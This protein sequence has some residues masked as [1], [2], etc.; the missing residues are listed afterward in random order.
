MS[1]LANKNGNTELR[2]HLFANVSTLALLGYIC[3]T[4]QTALASENGRPTVWIELG[5]QLERV[6]TE[7]TIF[8]PA[9]FDLASQADRDVMIGSQR[10]SRYSIGGAGKIS[11]EPEG[12]DWVFSA[13]VRYG[14]SNSA[15]HRHHEGPQLPVQYNTYLGN[16][17]FQYTPRVKLFGDG[18]TTSRET[19]LI[20]DFLA[21]KDVGLGLF[22][23]HSRSTFNAGVRFAQFVSKSDVALHAR[24]IAYAK[25]KYY[26]GLAHLYFMHTRGYTAVLHAQRNSHAIGPEISWDGFAVVAQSDNDAQLS[27]DWGV[28]AAVLFGRQRAKTQHQTGGSYWT[29]AFGGVANKISSYSFNGPQ[30]IRSKTVTIPNVGGF[31]GLSLRFPNAKVSLGYRADFF[32]NAVDSSIDSHKS[33][34]QKFYGP[35]AN[36]SIGLGR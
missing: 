15:R 13:S 34:D 29:G 33:A 2:V 6:D 16:L 36:I 8:A 28:N 23:A 31:A 9:F 24:P 27:V 4:P 32:F 3:A 5:S 20:V 18:Q 1:E 21:G 30:H 12:T 11:F 19:H 25:S 22:G 14:R 17:L 26:P 7:Q 35:F 10:P